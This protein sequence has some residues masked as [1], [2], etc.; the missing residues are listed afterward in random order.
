MQSLTFVAPG[1]VELREVPSPRIEAP[2]QA[3]VRPIA[4]SRCDLDLAFVRGTIPAPV[5]FALGHECTADVIAVGDDVKSVA[6]GDRVIV[7]FQISCGS[8]ARCRDGQTGSCKAVPKLAAFGLAPFSGVELGGALSDVMRVPFADAM[9][10]ALP[11]G[12]DPVVAAALGDNAIDGFRTVDR[13]LA[14][15][16]GADVLVAGGGAISV[17]LYAVSAARALGARTVVYVDPSPERAE[18]AERLGATVV[19]ALPEPAL[20][21]GRFPITVDATSHPDGLRFTLASTDAGGTCTSVGVYFADVPMPLFDMYSRGIEFLTGRVDARRDLPAAAALATAGF[22][23][24]TIATTV[25]D[26]SHAAEA[27]VEPATK[28][29]IRAARPRGMTS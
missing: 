4:V 18:L 28:L 16:P 8:C 11:A 25:V 3:L 2:G 10:V 12:V 22:D 14:R 9:L 13:A 24:A 23:L 19:R 17:G 1:R 5:P 26:W 20:R 21:A 27:W 7:P 15:R 6:V 29:V